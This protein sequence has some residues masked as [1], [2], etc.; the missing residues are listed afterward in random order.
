MENFFFFKW[1]ITKSTINSL[2]FLASSP[3]LCVCG[4][5][6]LQRM[7]RRVRCLIR[8]SCCCCTSV[9]CCTHRTAFPSS[10]AP[11]RSCSSTA[12]A[13]SMT[14][15]SREASLP[16]CL[17]LTAVP[18]SCHQS[19]H[20]GQGKKSLPPIGQSKQRS[21]RHMIWIWSIT[22]SLVWVGCWKV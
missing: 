11:A 5:C 4:V 9:T 13:T 18:S 12:S 7:T 3:L 8:T 21:I 1:G 19:V 15:H 2:R 20:I 16:L 17:N 10:S 22:P 6:M 14:R